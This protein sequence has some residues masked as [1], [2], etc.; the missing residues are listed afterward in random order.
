[1]QRVN[2]AAMSAVEAGRISVLNG[3]TPG[4]LVTGSEWRVFSRILSVETRDAPDF[5]DVTDKVVELV[6]ES[7]VSSG[8]V[9]IH[10]THTTCS[11]IINENEPLLLTDM[12]HFLDR[13]APKD[14][15]YGHNDFAI[16]TV[17]VRPN[18]C[19]NGHAHCQHMVLGTNETVPVIDGRVL[20]GEFQRIL[21]VELD[22][23]KPRKIAVQVTGLA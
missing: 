7:G 13:M 18:E 23:P 21:V 6:T 17:S 3:A 4:G 12:E 11:V 8:Q 20:L 19:P 14:M 1:M 22:E 10:S 5:V 16:R 2:A 15:Y 9:I